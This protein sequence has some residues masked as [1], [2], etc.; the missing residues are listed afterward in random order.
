MPTESFLLSPSLG[1]HQYKHIDSVHIKLVTWKK[2]KKV[3]FQVAIHKRGS[4]FDM[5][6]EF[7]SR[8]GISVIIHFQVLADVSV[9]LY[10]LCST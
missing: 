9:C 1:W 2:S 6:D 5:Q 7:I 8:F 4:D 10:T 3:N